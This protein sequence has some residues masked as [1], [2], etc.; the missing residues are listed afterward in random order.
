M[1]IASSLSIPFTQDPGILE[2]G[3][4]HLSSLLFKL[5]IGSFVNPTTF[6]GHMDSSGGLA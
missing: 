4:S 2:G 3:L 5:F 1:V 6:V